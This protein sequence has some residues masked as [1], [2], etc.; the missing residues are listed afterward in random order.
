VQSLTLKLQP[1]RPGPV[2]RTLTIR[3]DLDGGA[4]VTA[5]VEAVVNP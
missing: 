5:R 2:N 4:T 1:T 3:T